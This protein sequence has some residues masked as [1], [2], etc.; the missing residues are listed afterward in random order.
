[1][2]RIKKTVIAAIAA[3]SCF[4]LQAQ[5]IPAPP[6]INAK[7]YFLVDFTT[8]KVI[9][10]GENFPK[11]EIDYGMAATNNLTITGASRWSQLA[12]TSTQPRTD[13]ETW[14]AACK[15]TPNTIVMGKTA[16]LEFIKF[17]VIR[18][19]ID[20]NYRGNEESRLD[21]AAGNGEHVQFKGMYGSYAVYVYT[22]SYDDA[23]GDEQ[24]FIS[25]TRLI[26]CSTGINGAVL[27]GAIQHLRALRGMSRFPTNWEQED[28]SVEFIMTQSAP[29]PA[30][31]S[32]DDIC[33]VDL[34]GGA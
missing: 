17:D 16:Y 30:L 34:D 14:A 13:I 8:G 18:D 1:M 15:V 4:S 12:V 2:N 23:N 26:M 24:R 22:G 25:D 3:A 11:Q 33:T 20:N 7:G 10:E 27:Y 28:P 5:I 21:R 9:A 29:L 32:I 31:P 6:Q 19:V